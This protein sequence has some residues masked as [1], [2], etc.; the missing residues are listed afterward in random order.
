MRTAITSS[1]RIFFVEVEGEPA[2]VRDYMVA[3]QVYLSLLEEQFD[4]AL[5]LISSFRAGQAEA[6]QVPALL[7]DE[8]AESATRWHY[9]HEHAD[10]VARPLLSNPRAQRFVFR[11]GARESVSAAE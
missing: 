10:R 4:N 8:E 1:G 9:A 2:T 7:N 3:A 5:D 11:L 6:A